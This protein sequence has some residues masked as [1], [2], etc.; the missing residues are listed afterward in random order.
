MSEEIVKA[1]PEGTEYII[2]T[3]PEG[4]FRVRTKAGNDFGPFPDLPA[5]VKSM[6]NIVNPEVHYY[7]AKGK[8]LTKEQKEKEQEEA[9]AAR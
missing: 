8:E 2:I 1:A 9:D 7:D 5:A 3:T 6:L 4:K